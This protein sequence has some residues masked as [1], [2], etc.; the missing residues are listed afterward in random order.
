VD[1]SGNVFV[2]GSSFDFHDSR[3]N[4]DYVT[5]KYSGV[6]VPLWTN[7]YNGPGNG[8]DE[9][10]AVAVDTSGNVFVTGMSYTG[11]NG[12]LDYATIAY[13]NAG[14]PLWTNCYNGPR[15]HI[16]AARAIAVDASGN[17]FVTGVSAGNGDDYATIKYSGTGLPLWTNRY[18]GGHGSDGARAIAV[19]ASGNAVVTGGSYGSGTILDFATIKYSGAGLPLWTNRHKGSG[20]YADE[21]LAIAVDGSGNVLVTGY[22][23]G[24]GSYYTTLKYSTAG[25]PL[26]T[27]RYWGGMG[28]ANAIAVDRSGNA[29]VTGVAQGTNNDYVT[30]KYSTAGP[31][32]TIARTTTNTVAVSW[33]SPAADF[34]LQQNTN[35]AT[36]NWTAVGLSPTDDGTNNTVIID[37][38]EGIRFYRLFHP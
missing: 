8:S 33:P 11:T 2:T 34:A 15:N 6:G 20:G 12:Y 30:I 10:A 31:S 19:D 37:P 13:S 5:I 7:R 22:S 3:S 21:A 23:G 36:T 14:L 4:P 28:Y 9:A 17:I 27:N 29:F 18:D 35:M 26:W 38:P 24:A 1:A 16:D 32:L 25:L